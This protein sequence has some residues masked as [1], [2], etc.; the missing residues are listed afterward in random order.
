MNYL[1]LSLEGNDAR[2]RKRRREIGTKTLINADERDPY[3]TG[4][5]NVKKGDHNLINH[6]TI[7][8]LL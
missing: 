1:I 6:K 5:F 8:A 7:M 2:A 3:Q 4:A